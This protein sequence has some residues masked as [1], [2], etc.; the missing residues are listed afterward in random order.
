VSTITF[1]VTHIWTVREQPVVTPIM[2]QARSGRRGPR[3]WS[4][5]YVA[6]QQRHC[7]ETRR[8]TVD[9]RE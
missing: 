7:S 9:G 3:T 4:V 2:T 5:R 6:G 8:V 1:E